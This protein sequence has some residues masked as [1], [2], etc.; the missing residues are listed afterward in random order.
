MGEHTRSESRVFLAAA[1]KERA[2]ATLSRLR[3]IASD[4]VVVALNDVEGQLTN[5]G[6]A[7]LAT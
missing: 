1:D 6:W 2:Q 4:C 3:C 5:S 7:G